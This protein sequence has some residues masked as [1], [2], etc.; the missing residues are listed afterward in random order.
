MKKIEQS[1]VQQRLRQLYCSRGS[2][3]MDLRFRRL[4]GQLCGQ[5][6]ALPQS[7]GVCPA[8]GMGEAGGHVRAHCYCSE[9]PSLVLGRGVV[10]LQVIVLRPGSPPARALAVGVVVVQHAGVPVRALGVVQFEAVTPLWLRGRVYKRPT[11][12][13]G[14]HTD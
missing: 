1:T 9:A 10:A 14:T 7:C 13:Q 5:E 3:C 12:K 6:G 2:F 8:L 4:Q 11:S